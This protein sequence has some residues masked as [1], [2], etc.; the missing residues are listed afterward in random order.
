[1]SDTGELFR[2]LRYAVLPCEEGCPSPDRPPGGCAAGV[3][4]ISLATEGV[5]FPFH[6]REESVPDVRRTG[7][8]C[9]GGATADVGDTARIYAV[10]LGLELQ[11]E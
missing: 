11:Q 8:L 10:P 3:A 7:A 5:I 2:N 9:L 4:V 6:D 1:M